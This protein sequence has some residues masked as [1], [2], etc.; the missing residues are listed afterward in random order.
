MRGVGD[1]LAPRPVGALEP[2]P[3]VVERARQLV[4]LVAALVDDRRREIAR[5]DPP[6]R[7]LQPADARRQGDTRPAAPTSQRRGQRD[8]DARSARRAA[9]CSTVRSTSFSGDMNSSTTW[10]PFVGLGADRDRGLGR[11]PLAGPARRGTGVALGASLQRERVGRHV[12]ATLPATW[13]EVAAVVQRREHEP[14][15]CPSAARRPLTASADLVSSAEQA[16]CWPSRCGRS[17]HAGRSTRL[18]LQRRHD[19]Q[20]RDARAR[21]PPPPAPAPTARSRAAGTGKMIAASRRPTS[22]PRSDSRRRARS[23]CTA[24][25]SARLELLAQVTDVH[26]DRARLAEVGRA[27]D[28]V[29]QLRAREHPARARHQ[30]LQ[31]LELDVGELDRARRRP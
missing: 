18:R 16:R 27:P 9:P 26:V 28:A 14:R 13:Q 30:H 15:G 7:P 25:R 31:Q 10:R 20:R 17:R 5:G 3:H 22:S 23:G 29:E 6:R 2:S 1:E 21:A 8:R 4:D 11:V 19:Q 24:A 12:R